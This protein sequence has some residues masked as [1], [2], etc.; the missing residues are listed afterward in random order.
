[1]IVKAQLVVWYSR[2]EVY[3]D[4][5]PKTWGIYVGGLKGNEASEFRAQ[6]TFWAEGPDAETACQRVAKVLDEPDN[7]WIRKLPC[8][9][10]EVCLRARIRIK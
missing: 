8:R 6:Q 7:L 5:K 10:T 4:T 2:I 1:M 3:G 9:T